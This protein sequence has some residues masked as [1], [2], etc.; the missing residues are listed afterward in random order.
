LPNIAIV[1]YVV[2]NLLSVR[3]ALEQ[4]GASAI[5]TRLTRE[6]ERADAIVLPGVGAFRDAQENLKGLTPTIVHHIEAGKPL[7]GICLGLQLLFTESTEGGQ[8]RGLDYFKGTVRRLPD[9]MKVPHMGWNTVE[10]TQTANPL[11]E[12]LSSGIYVY[13]VHSYYGETSEREDTVGETV[14]GVRFASIM[15]RGSIYATQF[16]PEKSGKVGLQL[17]ENFV[18]IVRR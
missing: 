11:V 15:S 12:G 7:L 6:L 13:F 14:Y 1:D 4:V 18:K 16:H 3:K 9:D 17:L 2:G 10:I 5:V 8:Y